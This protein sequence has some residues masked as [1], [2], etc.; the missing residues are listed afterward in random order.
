MLLLHSCKTFRGV[1]CAKYESD[2]SPYL[3]LSFPSIR[4]LS[5]LQ[6]QKKLPNQIYAQL[7]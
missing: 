4:N 6:R 7:I 2:I 1:P 3:L 5:L